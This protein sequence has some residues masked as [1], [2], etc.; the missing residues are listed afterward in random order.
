MK[1]ANIVEAAS[2]GASDS[3]PLVA[4]IAAMLIAFNSLIYWLNDAVHWMGECVGFGKYC[5]FSIKL[6]VQLIGFQFCDTFHSE[7][8]SQKL[9]SQSWD[10]SLLFFIIWLY[11]LL[12][13]ANIATAVVN[14][15]LDSNLFEK[16][17]IKN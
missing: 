4:N 16:G 1:A 8:C 2:K 17:R 15:L 10:H 11:I 3:I 5:L 13:C 9:A 12:I 14:K 7:H 6:S